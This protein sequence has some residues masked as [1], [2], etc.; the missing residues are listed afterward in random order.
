MT[1]TTFQCRTRHYVC[2]DFNKLIVRSGFKC[3]FNAAHSIVCVGTT[4]G[5]RSRLQSASFNAARS[6]VCVGT[7]G[8][9]KDLYRVSWFQYR[10]QHCVCRDNDGSDV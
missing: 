7:A 1:N 5:L 2:R 6:I 8:W 9:G 4:R 10:T 3:S